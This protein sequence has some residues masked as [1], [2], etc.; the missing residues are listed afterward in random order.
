VERYADDHLELLKAA[1]RVADFAS[2][3][4]VPPS[5]QVR[6]YTYE[7]AGAVL[8]D[9]ILQAGLN[10]KSVVQ[11]RVNR[12]LLEFPEADTIGALICIVKKGQASHLLDWKDP[13][14]SERFERLVLFLHRSRLDTTIDIRAAL[15]SDKFRIGLLG[16]N[17]IGPKTID[18]MACLVGIESIAVDRHIRSFAARAGI[19]EVDY[20]F[21]KGV[22]CFAADLLSVSRREF[23]AWVWSNESQQQAH[24]LDFLF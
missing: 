17:G 19:H 2:T 21:L 1:R 14:K 24:Q 9:S 7:H 11:P 15:S 8:A 22:F 4:G 6:R 13:I 16:L 12:I 23:D 5:H 10:Y 3:Q 20:G 18:Y